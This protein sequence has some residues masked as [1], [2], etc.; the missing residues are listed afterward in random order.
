MGLRQDG[1]AFLSLDTAWLPH[2]CQVE[3]PILCGHD[4]PAYNSVSSLS[5]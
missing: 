2:I 1:C 4:G 3:S 5:F